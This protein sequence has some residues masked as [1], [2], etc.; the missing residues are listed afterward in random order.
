M[1]HSH[2]GLWIFS[3]LK[4]LIQLCDTPDLQCCFMP[5]LHKWQKAEVYDGGTM[6]HDNAE[7][8]G[9]NE[10]ARQVA[11]RWRQWCMRWQKRGYM[12]ETAKVTVHAW[13]G[14]SAGVCTRWQ[15]RQQ[16][17]QPQ[18]V[19]PQDGESEGAWDH[20]MAITTV[21]RQW[22]G[23]WKWWWKWRCK[24]EDGCTKGRWRTVSPLLCCVPQILLQ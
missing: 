24:T 7:V 10:D 22:K 2:G 21:K 13:D 20:K 14:K 8:T 12:N 9:E 5:L 16:K 17:E 15:T 1:N 23:W 11:R 6:L 4:Y 18:K 3:F 19:R